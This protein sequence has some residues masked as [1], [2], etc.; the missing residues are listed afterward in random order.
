MKVN[1][2]LFT[3]RFPYG[4]GEEFLEDEIVWLAKEFEHVYIVPA[5]CESNIIRSVPENCVVIPQIKMLLP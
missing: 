4:A 1:L 3:T 2:Y 5:M